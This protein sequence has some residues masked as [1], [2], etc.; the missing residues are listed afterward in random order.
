MLR[1]IVVASTAALVLSVACDHGNP[2]APPPPAPPVLQNRAPIA[3]ISGPATGREGASIEFSA[4]SSTDSDPSDSL[5]YTWLSGD[6]R[7][8]SGPN[9]G[10]VQQGWYYPDDGVYRVTVIV[11]D[12]AG[13]ADTA[14]TNVTIVN[15]A[16]W[17]ELILPPAQEAVGSPAPFRISVRDSGL[18]DTSFVLVR[19]GDG[20]SD[21]GGPILPNSAGIS[22]SHSYATPGS[23]T[24]SVT[25]RDDDGS[26]G[27][28]NTATRPVIVFDPAVRKGVAGYEVSDLGT[29][30][31]S[32]ARPNDF[33]DYGQI[34]GMSTTAT[35]DTHAFVWRNG[36]MRD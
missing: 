35:A 13:A 25:P 21:S 7:T 1:R 16:P 27:S 26:V 4:V 33:N 32:S 17:V 28:E 12:R 15:T 18:V 2:I 11:T 36:T 14:S 6:G 8:F 22:V 23:Y 34:V 5:Q 20:R 10:L 24:V 3:H 19:W 9:V 30:G 31:G 29:L